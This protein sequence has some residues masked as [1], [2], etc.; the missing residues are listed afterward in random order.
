MDLLPAKSLAPGDRLGLTTVAHTLKNDGDQAAQYLEDLARHAATADGFRASAYQLFVYAA[1]GEK[2]KAFQWISKAIESKSPLLLI[3]FVDPL[4]ESLKA[5]PR[6]A[7]FQKIIFPDTA[8]L[9]VKKNRKALLDK[10]AIAHYTHQLKNHVQEKKPYLDPGLSL[11]ALA[12]Q[13]GMHPNQLSW[14][15]N[16]SIGKNFSEFVNHY[17]VE[18]FKQLAKDPGNAHLTLSGLAYESGFN[19][20]TVFNTYFK[21]QTGLTPKQYLKQQ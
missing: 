18:A 7:Q 19:S 11:R 16:E 20:K 12:E 14:L 17:R 3:Y 2:E 21:Q 8:S 6:Y 4:V 9:E 5:D 10:Q 15:L 13:L 1:W